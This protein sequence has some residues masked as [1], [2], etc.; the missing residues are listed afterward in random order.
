M[1]MAVEIR[2]LALSISG[3]SWV[4]DGPATPASASADDG[5]NDDVLLRLVDVEWFD[6]KLTTNLGFNGL[7]ARDKVLSESKR[8]M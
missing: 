6:R 5:D 7:G 2:L 3:G 1:E 8:N 4:D